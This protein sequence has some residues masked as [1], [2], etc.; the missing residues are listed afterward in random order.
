[1]IDCKGISQPFCG[2]IWFATQ[3]SLRV[4]LFLFGLQYR[5]VCSTN[6][7]QPIGKKQ[8]WTSPSKLVLMLA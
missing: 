4:V 1:M 8:N 5:V 3:T 7:A 2:Q 6:N